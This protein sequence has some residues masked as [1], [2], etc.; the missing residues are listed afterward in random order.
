MLILN[1]GTASEKVI[2]TFNEFKTLTNPYYLFVFTNL[3]TLEVVTKIINS[4]ADSSLYTYRY[5][6]FTIATSTLFNGKPTGMWRYDAYEQASNSNT[7][8]ANATTL[9]ETG[10]LLLQAVT[11]FAYTKYNTATSIKTYTQ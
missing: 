10:K 2:V 11:P 7:N 9:V 5:N 3:N 8:P 1:I 6:E 4:T